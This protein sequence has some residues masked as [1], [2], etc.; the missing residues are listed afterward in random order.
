MQGNTQ[1]PTTAHSPSYMLL[2]LH[3]LQLGLS[4]GP[5]PSVL[6]KHFQHISVKTKFIQTWSKIAQILLLSDKNSQNCCG[7]F[8]I[9]K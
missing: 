4:G 7:H 5:F 1:P 8:N 3:L 6:S 2:N 9:F